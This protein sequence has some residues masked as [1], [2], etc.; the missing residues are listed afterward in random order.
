MRRC[1]TE[2]EY[3]L[4]KS[5]LAENFLIEVELALFNSAMPVTFDRD[6]NRHTLLAMQDP[7]CQR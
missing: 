5:E 7:A 6:T 4:T 1:Y 3:S 2:P